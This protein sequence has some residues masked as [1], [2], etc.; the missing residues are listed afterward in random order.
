[1]QRVG[2]ALEHYWWRW[3]CPSAAPSAGS[4]PLDLT[5]GAHR[6]RAAPF[7]SFHDPSLLLCCCWQ[8]RARHREAVHPCARGR[9]D[10]S[11]WAK[12]PTCRHRAQGTAAPR[13]G[14]DRRTLT[15][16]AWG[17]LRPQESSP[18]PRRCRASLAASLTPANLPHGPEVQSRAP[19]WFCRPNAVLAPC[20]PVLPASARGEH[21][22]R[23]PTVNITQCPLLRVSFHRR[24]CC[25]SV[26]PLILQSC[27]PGGTASFAGTWLVMSLFV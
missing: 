26:L 16:C 6:G 23:L 17:N 3:L 11:P 2:A 7:L 13:G 12:F 9:H 10:I 14:T 24:D 8:R 5:C 18:E 20:A 19:A 15:V 27:A 4:F 25:K 21:R 22:I 1:M